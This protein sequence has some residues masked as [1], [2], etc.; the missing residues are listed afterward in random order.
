LPHAKTRKWM[1]NWIKRSAELKG[2]TEGKLSE[3]RGSIGWLCHPSIF[4]WLWLTCN[5]VFDQTLAT[6]NK[7]LW[8]AWRFW[9]W[10]WWWWNL[11]DNWRTQTEDFFGRFTVDFVPLTL[12]TRGI[13]YSSVVFQF[14]SVLFSIH[15]FAERMSSDL[16]S[17]FTYKLYMVF[18]LLCVFSVS[19]IMNTKLML[20]V[21]SFG[22]I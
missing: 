1:S 7:S 19:A 22:L 10:W 17:L 6:V 5:R 15:L 11:Q 2:K 16:L 8:S 9:W 21:L 18:S 4:I 20:W 14:P 13:F 3:I 12:N